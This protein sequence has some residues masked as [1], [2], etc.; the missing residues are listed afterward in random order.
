MNIKNKLFGFS[1]KNLYLA[2]IKRKMHRYDYNDVRWYGLRSFNPPKYVLVRKKETYDYSDIFT[3]TNY[4][5]YYTDFFPEDDELVLSNLFPIV[6]NKRRIKYK[7]TEEIL[8][9]KNATYI[10]K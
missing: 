4:S 10:K 3:K 5:T 2:E 7:D 9:T 6:S 8:K 1:T